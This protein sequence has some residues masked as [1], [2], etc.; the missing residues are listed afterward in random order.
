MEEL[1]RVAPSPGDDNNTGRRKKLRR[2]DKSWV[3]TV[4][5]AVLPC[6]ITSFVTYRQSQMETQAKLEE[7]HIKAEAGYDALVKAVEKLQARDEANTRS[8]YELTGHINAIEA[9]VAGMKSHVDPKTKETHLDLQ[10]PHHVRDKANW[11][12]SFPP[13]PSPPPIGQSARID[14]PLSLD[15]AAAK[16]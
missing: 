15:D 12:P 14:L 9:L 4:L 7:A 10:V 2:S 16:K 13:P 5:A 6:L 8:I 3:G 11:K 1:M